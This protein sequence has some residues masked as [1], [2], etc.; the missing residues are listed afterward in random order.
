M[1]SRSPAPPSSLLQWLAAHAAACRLRP[2]P[3]PGPTPTQQGRGGSS[4]LFAPVAQRFLAGAIGVAEQLDLAV[5]REAIGHPRRRDEHVV[6][7][8]RMLLVAELHLAAT[9]VH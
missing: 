8:Q 2:A 7:R 5:S 1:E 6:R 4:D 3:G 9:L